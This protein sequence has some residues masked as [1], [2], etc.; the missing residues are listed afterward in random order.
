MTGLWGEGRNLFHQGLVTPD[1]TEEVEAILHVGKVVHVQ[2][3]QVGSTMSLG[4]DCSRRPAPGFIAPTREPRLKPGL[5]RR[6]SETGWIQ[7]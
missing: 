5:F 2:A 4:F 1:P 3:S 6:A 7:R